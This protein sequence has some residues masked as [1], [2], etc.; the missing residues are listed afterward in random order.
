MARKYTRKQLR[1]P[2]EFITMSHRVAGYVKDHAKLVAVSLL[3]A[4]VI[5]GAA[6]TLS[7]LSNSR[8]RTATAMLT[9]AIDIYNQTVVPNASK[10]KPR[11]DGI[12]HFET[13]DAKLKA[14]DEQLK[15]VVDKYG[16]NSVGLLAR[17]MRAS[18]SYERGQFNQAIDDYKRY[19]DRGGDAAFR[20]NAIEGLI[21][22]Y[23]KTK[24]YDKALAN[25]KKLPN[26]GGQRYVALYHE[27]RIFADQ[28]K[29]KAA[30]ERYRKVLQEANSPTLQ[31]QAGQQLALLEDK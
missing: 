2:D 15:K 27:A 8:A 17:L 11:E 20:N 16:D 21:Y 24:Q 9:R 25:V 30:A 5:I 7:W 22:S 14:A 4:A 26:S 6:W 1:K 18:V 10:L 31:N 23:E 28:G 13:R 19:L 3:V 29:A 12:P